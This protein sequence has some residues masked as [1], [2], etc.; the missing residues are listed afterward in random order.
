MIALITLKKIREIVKL[1]RYSITKL[2]R[3]NDADGH[4]YNGEELTKDQ[5]IFQLV[6]YMDA[7]DE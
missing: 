3:L 2:R 7:P 6:F 4:L 5:L 1:S